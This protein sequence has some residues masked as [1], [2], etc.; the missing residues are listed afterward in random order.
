MYLLNVLIIHFVNVHAIIGKTAF[1][2]RVLLTIFVG[3]TLV[4]MYRM[5]GTDKHLIT[6]DPCTLTSVQ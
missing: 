1:D 4:L 2:L 6:I 5:N 3:K